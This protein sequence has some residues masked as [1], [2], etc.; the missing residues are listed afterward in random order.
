[1]STVCWF[2]EYPCDGENVDL[3][4]FLLII[5]QLHPLEKTANVLTP[6]ARPPVSFNLYI[7]F[8]IFG[9]ILLIKPVKVKINSKYKFW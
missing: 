7:F 3:L 5:E 4:T 9:F 6:F 1:M 2:L 8:Y